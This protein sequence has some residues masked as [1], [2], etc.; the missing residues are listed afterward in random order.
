MKSMCLLLITLMLSSCATTTTVPRLVADKSRVTDC[1][2]A[3][4]TCETTTETKPP[5]PTEDAD[6]PRM[7]A[8]EIAHANM[9][10]QQQHAT[11]PAAQDGISGW[12][13]LGAIALIPL[14]IPLALI[15]G[16]G[17]YGP[18]H[19]VTCRSYVYKD[20]PHTTCY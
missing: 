5:L 1:D 18:Y 9:L 11:P 20:D 3:L 15:A 7:N 13:V 14:A 17:S 12:D 16:Y 19:R 8:A 2:L 6:A 4:P 10:I